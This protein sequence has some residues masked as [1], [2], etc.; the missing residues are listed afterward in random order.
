MKIEYVASREFRPV[1]ITIENKNEA[2]ILA[3]AIRQLI[4]NG[5]PRF[6]SDLTLDQVMAFANTLSP[7]IKVDY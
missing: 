3:V 1:S 4:L 5:I 7:F 6:V 2:W